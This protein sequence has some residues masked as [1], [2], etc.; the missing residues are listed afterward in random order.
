MTTGD[1]VQLVL[2]R[3]GSQSFALTIFQVERVLR[4]QEPTPLPNAPAF[5]EGVFPYGDRAVPLVDLR[6]RL[7]VPAPVRDETRVIV[8]QLDVGLVGLAVDAVLTVRKVAAGAIT[9]PTP[10]VQGLAAE[11]IHGLVVV[12]TRT[13]VVLAVSRLLTS[14]E[15]V[16]L[17]DL[18]VEAAP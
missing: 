4:Y 12:D 7:G 18:T 10:L 17:R 5:L 2:F 15:Q 16:A 11:F 14:Q 8:V 3:V 6:R 13:V 1:E 9:P